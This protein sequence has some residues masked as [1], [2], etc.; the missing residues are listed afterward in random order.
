MQ[1]LLIFSDFIYW[2]KTLEWWILFY[3]FKCLERCTMFE[4][5]YHEM[6]KYGKTLIATKHFR[7]CVP[8]FKFSVRMAKYSIN[9]EAFFLRGSLYGCKSKLLF[10]LLKLQRPH[11]DLQWSLI[12]SSGQRG[13]VN[14]SMLF[15]SFIPTASGTE[16]FATK[17][18]RQKPSPASCCTSS[19]YVQVLCYCIAN[20]IVCCYSPVLIVS[21]MPVCLCTHLYRR[22]KSFTFF[23][24]RRHKHLS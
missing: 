9:L 5:I 10:R 1:E 4:Y 8:R 13:S 22:A 3:A 23:P 12:S 2:I 19:P 16:T 20:N 21:N 14:F 24:P 15:Q 17:T 18:E 11:K 6:G 7:P